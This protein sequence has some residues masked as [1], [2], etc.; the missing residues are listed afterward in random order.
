[1]RRSNTDPEAEGDTRYLPREAM[2]VL[3]AVRLRGAG[4]EDP[5]FGLS[6]RQVGRRVAAAARGAGLGEGFSG[7]TGL[8]TE[9]AH[10]AF[11]GN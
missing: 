3:E 2:R 6:G 1:M 4:P 8:A 7:R 10:L 11:I 9:S 5:V